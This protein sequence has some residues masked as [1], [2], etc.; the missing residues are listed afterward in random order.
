MSLNVSRVF[1][2]PLEEGGHIRQKFQFHMP[3]TAT[4]YLAGP[5]PKEELTIVTQ[6]IVNNFVSTLCFSLSAL[7]ENY[8]W[9]VEATGKT[10]GHLHSSG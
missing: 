4:Q 9:M 2:I 8:S 3:L 1:F 7:I 6:K 10:D 5:N